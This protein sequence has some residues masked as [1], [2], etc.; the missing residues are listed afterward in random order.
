MRDQDRALSIAEKA[1]G[2]AGSA[3]QAQVTVNFNRQSYARYAQ[4]YVTQNLT[5]DQTVITLTYYAGK[6]SGT[7]TSGD[8]SDEGLRRLAAAAKAIAERVPPDNDFVSLPKPA[9]IAQANA[10]FHESTAQATAADRVEKLLPIFAMMK[11]ADLSC[12][13]YTTTQINTIAIANSL[14]VRAAFTGTVG[15][16]ELK[17]MAPSTSGYGE[18]F[19]PDYAKLDSAEIAERAAARALV[20]STPGDLAPGV[21]PVVLEANA[22]ADALSAILG[23]MSAFNVLDDKDSW[24]IDRIG[25]PLFSPNLTIV[26][27]WSD[28]LFA[29]PP[30]D[31]GD[32]APTRR[33]TL[34]ERGV[35]RAFVSGAY[36]ANKFKIENTGHSLQFPVNAVVKPGTKSRE[37][38]IASVERGV[39]ISRTWYSRVVDPRQATITGLTRDG[40]F[41][42][43]HGKLTKTLKN[44]RFFTSMLEALREVDVGSRQVLTGPGETGIPIVVPDA[45]VARFNLSAQTSFA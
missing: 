19:G 43:E 7:T 20:S 28:P 14:G 41:L 29:N 26:D 30:F 24:M 18:F 17:A 27:D 25:K 40:V 37:E 34:I 39:L 32:G 22:F 11:K 10:A 38:L 42:I 9:P 13:G 3:D 21:Y 4:N 33:V 12:A 35:P 16:L 8:A 1:L 6:Q 44:F 31:A 45:K 36:S 2:Y 15:G 23:G 5:S